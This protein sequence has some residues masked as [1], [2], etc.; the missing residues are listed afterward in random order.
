[1]QIKVK[2]GALFVTGN[3]GNS[4]VRVTKDGV[5][6]VDTKNPGEAVYGELMAKI[7]SVTPGAVK[8]VFITH[9][10]QR[11]AGNTVEYLSTAEVI[12]RTVEAENIQRYAGRRARKPRC[13]TSSTP[14][15]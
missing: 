4:T 8:Y 12:S 7:K 11:Y 9:H 10:P 13:P 1:M 14:S 5:I 3:G 6:L 2:P 15:P